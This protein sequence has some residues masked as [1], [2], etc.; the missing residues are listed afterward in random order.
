M[1]LTLDFL[2]LI[3]FV[4]GLQIHYDLVHYIFSTCFMV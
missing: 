4:L 3:E 1:G 2:S